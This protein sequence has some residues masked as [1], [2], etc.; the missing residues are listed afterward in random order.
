MRR[1]ERFKTF[2]LGYYKDEEGL[3]NG[4]TPSS[5]NQLNIAVNNVG[6]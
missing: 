3:Y 4:P 2:K 1:E 6:L 5:V